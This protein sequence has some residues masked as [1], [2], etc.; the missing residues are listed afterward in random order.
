MR[1]LITGITGFAGGH[2]AQTLLDRGDEVFGV[3]RDEGMGLSHL[4]QEIKPVIADLQS[5]EVVNKVLV[6]VRPDAIYHLAGQA[7]VPTAWADPWDT[8]DIS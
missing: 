8:L 2:L 4:N 6:D 1:A 7:F 5:S 3:A